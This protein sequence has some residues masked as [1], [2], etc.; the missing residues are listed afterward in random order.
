MHRSVNMKG[1]A[2][3]LSE[4]VCRLPNIANVLSQRLNEKGICTVADFLRASEEDPEK[5]QHVSSCC[6]THIGHHILL[7]IC[8]DSQTY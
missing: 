5:L 3:S 8:I 7:I 2:P 6:S 1:K 4:P